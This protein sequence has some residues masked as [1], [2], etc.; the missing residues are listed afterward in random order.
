MGGP[1]AIINR[2]MSHRQEEV[3][4]GILV[5]CNGK[6]IYNGTLVKPL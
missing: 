5:I 1:V 3:G 2:E 4:I 6:T